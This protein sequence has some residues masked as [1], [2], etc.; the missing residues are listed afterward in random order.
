MSGYPPGGNQGGLS[1]GSSAPF[2]AHLFWCL[3]DLHFCTPVCVCVVCVCVCFFVLKKKKEKKKMTRGPTTPLVRW[4][5][6]ATTACE[7]RGKQP[8]T[9]WPTPVHK[10]HQAWP[11]TAGPF[12]WPVSGSPK[13]Q[14]RHSRPWQ[15][16]W[17]VRAEPTLGCT[18]V[19]P[20]PGYTFPQSPCRGV[21]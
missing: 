15:A 6:F 14:P 11:A 7:R 17:T 9:L 18:G 1:A 20:S 12:P 21:D 19:E 3:P 5:P 4:P 16:S 8:T 10:H 2:T 13:W